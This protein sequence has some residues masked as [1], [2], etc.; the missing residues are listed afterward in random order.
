MA[1]ETAFITECLAIASKERDVVNRTATDNIRQSFWEEFE[2]DVIRAASRI[3]MEQVRK[4]AGEQLVL[5]ERKDQQKQQAAKA[6]QEAALLPAEEVLRRGLA[7]VMKRKPK[8]K[9]KNKD[10]S[11]IDFSKLLDLNV[12]AVSEA[13]LK[14][15]QPA[16]KSEPKNGN[17]PAAGRGQNAKNNQQ[18]GKGSGK[19]KGSGEGAPSQPGKGKEP[20]GS[21][22]QSKGAGNGGKVGKKP[23]PK[24]A[25][26][27]Q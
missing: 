14:K 23:K 8:G 11:L 13:A 12:A 17:S 9:Q 16:A 10:Q 6:L 24:K 15:E 1:S 20:A 19:A 22:G 3:Y 26:K 27:K 2:D 25:T 21:K 18:A 7:E 4:I 5:E